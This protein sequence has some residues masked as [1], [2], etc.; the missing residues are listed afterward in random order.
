[1]RERERNLSWNTLRYKWRFQGNLILSSFSLL[2]FLSLEGISFV[3]FLSLEIFLSLLIVHLRFILFWLAWLYDSF[4][5]VSI[6]GTV[7][8]SFFLLKWWR[9]EK[10]EWFNCLLFFKS[11]FSSDEEETIFKR[12]GFLLFNC[13]SSR[14]KGLFFL[15]FS[16]FFFCPLLERLSFSPFCLEEGNTH[17]CYVQC[18]SSSFTNDGIWNKRLFF[19]FLL[20][21]FFLSSIPPRFF[22]SLLLVKRWRQRRE[23][24]S[25]KKLCPTFFTW[26]TF[27]W[28]FVRQLI[29]K[30]W[31]IFLSFFF[32]CFLCKLFDEFSF[33]NS[34]LKF[35]LFLAAF[36]LKFFLFS[37]IP[38]F[39]LN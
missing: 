6:N 2:I 30:P 1:M 33:S 35:F 17:S 34:L 9:N 37:K 22:L 7:F 10:K 29:I 4:L 23:L 15:S 3:S 14:L 21:F 16:F 8:F 39:V 28:V 19:L 11:S 27:W 25:K 5:N 31:V 24:G 13:Y 38:S 32:F 26:K 18:C 20:Y 36:S 12:W